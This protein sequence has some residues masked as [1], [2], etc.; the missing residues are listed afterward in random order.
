VSG[1]WSRFWAMRMSLCL[2]V[3]VTGSACSKD[4]RIRL[5]EIQRCRPDIGKN[6]FV[7]SDLSTLRQ[8]PIADI[9]RVLGPPEM[10]RN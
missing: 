1:E 9:V 3:L 10:C 2:V 8:I 4:P 5:E 7:K 6:C